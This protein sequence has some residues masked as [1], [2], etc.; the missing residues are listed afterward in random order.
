MEKYKNC[1][2]CHT[3]NP[4]YAETCTECGYKFGDEPTL[5][6]AELKRMERKKKLASALM[7]CFIFAV[8]ASLILA[9]MIK[10]PAFGGLVILIWLGVLILAV[11]VMYVVSKIVKHGDI[12]KQKQ[13]RR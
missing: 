5:T 10:G 1:P 13:N 8:L 3:I 4:P 6:D 2:V 12:E 9:T 11:L 7:S